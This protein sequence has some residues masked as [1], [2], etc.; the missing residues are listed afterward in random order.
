MSHFYSRTFSQILRQ[1][2]LGHV[3][4]FHVCPDISSTSIEKNLMLEQNQIRMENHR[5]KQES[6]EA[7]KDCRQ[8]DQII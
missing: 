3:T 2:F 8:N 4:F 6:V 7:R 1:Y 5:E